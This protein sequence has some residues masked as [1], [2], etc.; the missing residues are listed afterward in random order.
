MEKSEK[1]RARHAHGR[2]GS[3][4]GTKAE[5]GE[6]EKLF[7]F[8]QWKDR[9]QWAHALER[10]LSLW[11]YTRWQALWHSRQPY[12]DF[13]IGMYPIT[14]IEYSRFIDDTNRR[15]PKQW[16]EGAYPQQAATHPLAG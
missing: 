7:A 11:T 13:E 12:K 6:C 1:R 4:T 16:I 8:F 15:P 5:L 2:K 3:Y 10:S 9:R 14:N